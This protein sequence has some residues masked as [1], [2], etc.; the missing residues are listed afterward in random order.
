MLEW[1]S[2][3]SRTYAEVIEAWR[4]SCPRLSIWEDACIAGLVV[5]DADS[6]VVRVS[7]KGKKLLQEPDH[8]P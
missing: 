8:A 2:S 3:R 6:D 7:A 4:T 5:Q 1:I